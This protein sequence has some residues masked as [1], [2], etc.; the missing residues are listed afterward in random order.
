MKV[1]DVWRAA[2]VRLG[3]DPGTARQMIALIASSA[4]SKAEFDAWDSRLPE[5]AGRALLRGIE[6]AD[7]VPVSRDLIE[8]FRK[9]MMDHFAISEEEIQQ[10]LSGIGRN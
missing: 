6:S 4:S 8:Q 10:I 9:R 1:S 5:A 3:T 7:G 2:L